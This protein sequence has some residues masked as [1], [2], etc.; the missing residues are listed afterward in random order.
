MVLINTKG[1][2][3]PQLPYEPKEVLKD[4]PNLELVQYYVDF[5]VKNVALESLAKTIQEILCTKIPHLPLRIPAFWEAVRVE[6]QEMTQAGTNHIG[7]QEFETVCRNNKMEDPIKMK[8]LSR[9]LHDLGVILHYQD[10]HAAKLRDFVVLNPHWAVDAVYEILKH[11]KLKE[12]QGR[13]DQHFLTSVWDA[14]GYSFSEQS[15]LIDLMLK[16]N[17]EV[18]FKA[19]ENNQEIFIA[20]QLLPEHR[21]EFTWNPWETVATLHLSLSLYAQRPH[22]EANCTPA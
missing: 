22:W 20:P 17:F 16:N 21:P 1:N 11:D 7:Y 18:C 4:F 19:Q 15:H 14:K 5:A 9:M 8:D 13:F 6:L 12:Q 10:E 2:P 3:T